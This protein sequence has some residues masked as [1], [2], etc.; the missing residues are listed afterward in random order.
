VIERFDRQG[1]SNLTAAWRHEQRGSM[2]ETCFL[3]ERHA[4]SLHSGSCAA[5]GRTPLL[6]QFSLWR[7]AVLR[8]KQVL[9]WPAS[10][11]TSSLSPHFP[12]PSSET[13]QCDEHPSR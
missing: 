7:A 4:T 2:R 13:G 3:N 11:E 1:R 10:S 12:G 8:L 6:L 5:V 9:C